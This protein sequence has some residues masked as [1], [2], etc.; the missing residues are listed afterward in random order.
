MNPTTHAPRF[1]PVADGGLLVEFGTEIT[2]EAHDAVGRLDSVLSVA[3]IAGLTEIVPAM[4]NL[5]VLFDAAQTDHEALE[6]AVRTHMDVEGVVDR[7]ASRRTVQ[8]CYDESVA[9][10]LP[11]VASACGLTVEEVIAAHVAGEYR[12]FMYG[13]APGYAYLAG[14]RNEIQV[15]RKPRP[16]RGV[17]AGSVIIA[18]AQC[19]VTTLEMPTGWSVIGRSPTRI[20]L[21]DLEHPFLFDV[22]DEVA[23]ER[24]DMAQLDAHRSGPG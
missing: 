9:P 7:P 5:L 11:A 13:F 3:S 6:A 12:V 4:V 17:A 2:D 22:G 14:V 18:G 24:I 21:D 16:V 1:T 20:L 8:V 15:H 19:L 10:D 23:F